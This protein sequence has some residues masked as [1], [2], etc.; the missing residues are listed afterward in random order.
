MVTVTQ[1]S[2]AA[3]AGSIEAV[4][5]AAEVTIENLGK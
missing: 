2:V 4:H 5:E 1:A 3:S